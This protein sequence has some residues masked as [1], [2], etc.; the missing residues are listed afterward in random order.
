MS[1]HIVALSGGKDST[2]MALRLREVEPDVDFRFVITPTGNELPPMRDHWQTLERMLGARLEVLSDDTLEARMEAMDFLPSFHSRW[3]TRIL[4]IEPIERFYST[5]PRGSVAYVGLRADEPSRGG[6]YGS[7]VEQRCPLREWGW[8]LSEVQAYL[9]ARGVRIPARTDCAF[10]P[11]QGTDDWYRLWKKY[12]ELWARA[13]WWEAKTGATFRSP[14]AK[15][16]TWACSLAGLRTQFEGGKL[17]REEVRRRKRALPL[18]GEA[19]DDYG[20]EKCRVCRL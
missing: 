20:E 5:L 1:A 3:C 6:I 8:G 11:F 15:L 19:A 9:R 13:E 12:P 14:T 4:K 16:G 2:A 17:T 18:L 7:K 10:C